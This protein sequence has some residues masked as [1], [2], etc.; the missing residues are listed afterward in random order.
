[1]GEI[2]AR[3]SVGKALVERGNNQKKFFKKTKECDQSTCG[4]TAL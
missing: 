1:M 4:G 2:T 3:K